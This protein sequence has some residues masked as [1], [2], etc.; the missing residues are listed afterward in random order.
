MVRNSVRVQLLSVPDCPLVE[1]VR[2]VLENSLAQ[3]HVDVVVEELVGDYS[4]P[5]LLVNGFDVTGHPRAPEGQIS[6]RLVLP[7]EEQILAALRG[8]TVLNCEDTLV[9]RL[10]ATAFQ[11]LLQSAKPVSVDRLAIKLDTSAVDI[12]S[13]I[14]ELRRSG[15]VRLDS[16]DCVVGAVGLSLFPTTHELSIEGTRFW[17]WC[18]FDV[19]GI[20]RALHASGSAR[21]LDPHS[22]D[23]LRLEFVDGVPQSGSL[24]VFMA[25]LPS[26]SSL[27]DDWCSTVNFFTSVQSAEAWSQA[28]GVTGSPISVGNLVP[29]AGEVW[30]RLL[31]QAG[32]APAGHVNPK[33]LL[34]S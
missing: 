27:C 15:Q 7:T 24:A 14:E 2:S 33:S 11:S 34:S 25:D 3:T 5:T 31:E 4:S 17:A 1:S 30:S 29:V 13:C 6:C 18:A 23:I 16:E 8:L 28:N 26:Y 32:A 20:F 10:Q 9:G 12:S 19:I 22:N 21:S